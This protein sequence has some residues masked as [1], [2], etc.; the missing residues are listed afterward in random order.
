MQHDAGTTRESK[1]AFYKFLEQLNSAIDREWVTDWVRDT[2]GKSGTTIILC[3]VRQYF[4]AK[5]NDIGVRTIL[6]DPPRVRIKF[7]EDDMVLYS[8]SESPEGGDPRFRERGGR[9]VGEAARLDYSFRAFIE[10]MFL[11]EGKLL[12]SRTLPTCLFVLR[13]LC[14]L[15][16]PVLGAMSTHTDG[17]DGMLFQNRGL[18]RRSQ[19][20]KTTRMP[21]LPSRPSPHTHAMP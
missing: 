20:R 5:G 12:R 9:P 18:C 21:R 19:S 16:A 15:A 14:F 3:G 7:E 8:D 6:D 13:Q 11:T 4:R 1:E 2:G 17:T 10:V